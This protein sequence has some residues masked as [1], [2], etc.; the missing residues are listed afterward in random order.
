[1]NKTSNLSSNVS[2]SSVALASL[3]NYRSAANQA[4]GAYR[5][6]GHRLVNVVNS[7]LE[8]AVY[9]RTVK[10][11]P[12]ATHRLQALRGNWSQIVVKGIDQVAQRT[13][14]AIEVSANSAAE[15]VAK[16]VDMA[17]RVDN[18][19]VANGL[20]TAARFS[21]PGAKL[22][23][24]VSSKVAQGATKLYD[25][26]GG[27]PVV[28]KAV[29]K[30]VRKTARSVQAAVKPVVKARSAQAVKTVK[31]VKRA[32]SK[33][34]IAKPFAAAVKTAKATRTRAAK[35]ASI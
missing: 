26:A 20:Q 7:A 33:T 18:V 29:R 5:L 12:Q 32:V 10:L 15:Q 8:S 35:V 16:V 6:G 30:V 3:A 1:M 25:A 2:L 17:G 9:P 14:R 34:S 21:L 27:Q 4:V 11:A 24:V 23:L 28:V 13:E 31:R 22:A 19:M